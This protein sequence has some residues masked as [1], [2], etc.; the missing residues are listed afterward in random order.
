[1]N[2]DTSLPPFVPS[3]TLLLAAKQQSP[4]NT[5]ARLKQKNPRNEVLAVHTTSPKASSPAK[6]RN[7][8]SSGRSGYLQT[9]STQA[10]MDDLLRGGPVPTKLNNLRLT[11]DS[12]H[13]STEHDQNH[14]MEEQ[15]FK[16]KQTLLESGL[17]AATDDFPLQFLASY[18]PDLVTDVVVGVDL[19]L[20]QRVNVLFQQLCISSV[21][22]FQAAIAARNGE[23]VKTIVKYILQTITDNEG[24][25]V[26]PLVGTGQQ[27]CEVCRNMAERFTL[28]ELRKQSAAQISYATAATQLVAALSDAV[29]KK[30]EYHHP[31]Q[32]FRR[33]SPP[34]LAFPPEAALEQESF[35]FEESEVEENST[36]EDVINVKFK[37]PKKQPSRSVRSGE[38]AL[39][40]LSEAAAKIASLES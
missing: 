20:Q 18:S 8:N 19:P 14:T 16:E 38:D 36:R 34:D 4:S 27:W 22:T 40:L 2:D 39:Y 28:Q 37:R 26:T 12:K 10:I 6:K 35:R 17:L 29:Q 15:D 24:H 31:A 33:V 23:M 30:T 3:S 25:F 1:M 32:F 5:A 9:S 21:P 13:S 7:S 11:N